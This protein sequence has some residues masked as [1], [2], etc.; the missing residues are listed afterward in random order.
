MNRVES[1]LMNFQVKLLR[2]VLEAWREEVEKKPPVMSVED[3]YEALE[4]PRDAH[5]EEHVIR[6]AYYKLAQI[7]HPD[8]NPKGKVRVNCSGYFACREKSNAK[9]FSD[10]G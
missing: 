6:K 9:Q 3:A 2:D 5:H 10:D 8:K 1:G 4:L 7:Y